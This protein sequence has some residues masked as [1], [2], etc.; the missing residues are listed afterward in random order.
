MK[1]ILQVVMSYIL[2]TDK[3]SLENMKDKGKILNT[4]TNTVKM[5]T[6]YEIRFFYFA[7]FYYVYIFSIFLREA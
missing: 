3:I 7:R 1:L 4:N 2:M 6:F 5:L